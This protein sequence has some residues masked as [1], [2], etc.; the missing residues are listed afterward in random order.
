MFCDEILELIEPIAA[1]DLTPDGRASAH[2]ASCADCAAALESARGLE[3]VLQTRA[4]PRPT[5]QFTARIMGRLRR[6]RWRREQFL[7]AGFN[8]AI[9]AVLFGVL[10]AAWLLL[11]RSGLTG[12][13][14]QAVDVLNAA[15]VN[16]ARRVVPSLPLYAGAAALLATALGLWWWAE[17]DITLWR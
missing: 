16:V 7:D 1:G 2:L 14:Q 4:A 12:L 10:A 8:L 15:V 11:S 9:G 6:D 17:R 3:R 13:G 5:P